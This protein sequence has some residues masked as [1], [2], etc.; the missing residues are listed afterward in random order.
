MWVRVRFG[1]FGC[2]MGFGG[3][4]VCWFGLLMWFGV[5][6]NLWCRVGVLELLVGVLGMCFHLF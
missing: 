6:S 3:L 5:L 4:S 2:L 1:G